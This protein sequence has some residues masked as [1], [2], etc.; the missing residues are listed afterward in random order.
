MAKQEGKSNLITF[1][2]DDSMVQSIQE[3]TCDPWAVPSLGEIIL[4]HLGT[5]KR[6]R[7]KIIL[8]D[9]VLSL[10]SAKALEPIVTGWIT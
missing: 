5:K 10:R 8:P 2:R 6:K 3:C 7:S 1:Y 4:D 9:D